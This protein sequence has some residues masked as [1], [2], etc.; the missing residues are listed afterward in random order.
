MATF[1]SWLPSSLAGNEV[2]LCSLGNT[3]FTHLFPEEGRMLL[4]MP[5]LSGVVYFAGLLFGSG[6]VSQWLG[7]PGIV[8]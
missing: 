5:A 3:E 8:L 7:I 6:G 4:G 2:G 1:V